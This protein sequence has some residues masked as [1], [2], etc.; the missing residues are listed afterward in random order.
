[1]TVSFKQ[2]LEEDVTADIAKLQADVGAIDTA[3]TQRTANLVAQRARLQKMLA[4]KQKA[5]QAEAQRAGKQQAQQPAQQPMV[6]PSQ[7]Q[8]PTR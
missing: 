1:M 8:T 5:A 3:I 4:L 2:F 6:A 7:G